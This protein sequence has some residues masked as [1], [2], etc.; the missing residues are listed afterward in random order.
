MTDIYECE[1][2]K[3][4]EKVKE[5]RKRLDRERFDSVEAFGWYLMGG[6]EKNFDGVGYHLVMRLKL[7]TYED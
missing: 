7:L 1:Y 6:L 5:A 4:L 2:H 3:Y